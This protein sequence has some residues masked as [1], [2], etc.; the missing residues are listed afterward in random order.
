[1]RTI[2]IETLASSIADLTTA[3]GKELVVLTRDGKP[4]AFVRDASDYDWEDVGYMT[5][6]EFWKMVR[7]RRA[8]PATVTLEEVEAMVTRRE[9]AESRKGSHRSKSAKK[10]AS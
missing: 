4:F 10:K 7:E 8:E 9:A 6:P 5:D 3:I 1:M 2:A